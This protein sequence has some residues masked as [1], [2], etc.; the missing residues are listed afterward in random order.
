VLE[1]EVISEP[2]RGLIDDI[3]RRD[4]AHSGPGEVAIS[5]CRVFVLCV[6][7]APKRDPSAGIDEDRSQRSLP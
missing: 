3:A 1:P 6:V 7:L 5:R 2:C 4:E